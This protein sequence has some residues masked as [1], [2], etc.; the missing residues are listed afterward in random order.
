MAKCEIT[1]CVYNAEA[2]KTHCIQHR[3]FK[4]QPA[5]AP[6]ANFVF[7]PIGQVP[8]NARVNEEAQNLVLALKK[9]SDG[10]AIKVSIP[11]FKRITLQTAAR[12]A[13]AGGFQIGVRV[14]GASGYLWKLSP[15]EVAKRKQKSERIS[16]TMRNRGP[17]KGKAERLATQIQRNARA[18]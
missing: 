12:Y 15:A 3:P 2:G 5:P 8:S 4:L 17:R 16:T 10:Q 14:V 11:P 18:N 1:G 13:A 6:A 7:I 9:M